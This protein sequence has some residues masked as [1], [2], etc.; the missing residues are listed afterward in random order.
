MHHKTQHLLETTHVC[1]CNHPNSPHYQTDPCYNFCTSSNWS[2]PET[3]GYQPVLSSFCIHVQQNTDIGSTNTIMNT[4][5]HS[6]IFVNTDFLA[7]QM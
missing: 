3:T 4:E 5:F 2:E 7:N 1:K 6:I